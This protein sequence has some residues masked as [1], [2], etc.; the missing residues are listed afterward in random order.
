MI[1]ESSAT[2]RPI[3]FPF[4]ISSFLSQVDPTSKTQLLIFSYGIF[5]ANTYTY[6][7]K[8]REHDIIVVVNAIIVIFFIAW[9]SVYFQDV[10]KKW[11]FEYMF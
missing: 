10:I 11:T 5:Q 6:N 4:L 3:M 8:E 2:I 1:T 7:W 9:L